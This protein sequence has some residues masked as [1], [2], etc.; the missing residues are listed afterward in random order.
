MK[1]NHASDVKTQLS[2][3]NW[4]EI[5][6][7][8]N[9]TNLS[10]DDYCK[11][12]GLSRNSYYY[13]LRKIRELSLSQSD[14]GSKNNPIVEIRSQ[15]ITSLIPVAE[16]EV[17]IITLTVNGITLSVSPDI[18]PEFLRRTLEVIRLA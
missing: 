11:Q 16:Q 8:R 9:A 2:I 7:D 14:D 15:Q 12:H 5:I 18:S 6:K 10:I 4:T 3:Q 13:W 1:T 17:Q